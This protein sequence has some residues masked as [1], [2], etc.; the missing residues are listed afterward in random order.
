L[1]AKRNYKY[2]LSLFPFN[3]LTIFA[4]ALY[5]KRFTSY[6]QTH[7]TVVLFK[8]R[9][10]FYHSEGSKLLTVISEDLVLPY[11]L[12]L[13]KCVW[14]LIFY[15][16]HRLINFIA[17]EHVNTDIRDPF[18]WKQSRTVLICVGNLPLTHC[19]RSFIAVYRF[20]ISSGSL[21]KSSVELYITLFDASYES[22]KPNQCRGVFS[23]LMSLWSV[24]YWAQPRS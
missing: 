17:V 8:M 5:N 6:H 24:M 22:R 20:K 10:I 23:P 18:I 7:I 15:R 16:C 1:F 11:K 21:L 12:S 3:I 9:K 19:R 4:R 2:E 14:R 13:V